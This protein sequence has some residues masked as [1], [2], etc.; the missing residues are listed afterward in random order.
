M[1]P[2]ID[3]PLTSTTKA[4][5]VEVMDRNF[6]KISKKLFNFTKSNVDAGKPAI[7]KNSIYDVEE[8]IDETSVSDMIKKMQRYNIP[9]MLDF[10]TY[11][12]KKGE[13]PFVMYIFEFTETLDKNDLSNIWQGLMP[14]IS[15]TATKQSQIIEHEMNKVNFFEGKEIPENIRWMVFRVKRKA[16]INYF[17]VTADSQD[18]DRFKFNFDF[19]IKEP[20]YSYNWPY[21]F[22]SLVEMARIKGGISVLPPAPT[23]LGTAEPIKSNKA[24]QVIEAHTQAD[25]K[26][27]IKKTSNNIVDW[28]DTK[29][30]DE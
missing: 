18:D 8:D 6:F 11:P 2:F 16:N 7:P 1:V 12:L 14:Q 4:S 27:L 13:F 5:T 26:M 30:N 21:D 17:Q 15:R 20:E 9:P 19:G 24:E 28:D 3:E 10:I 23:I 22:C 29:E 25:S